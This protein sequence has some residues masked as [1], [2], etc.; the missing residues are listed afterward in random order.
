MKRN[1]VAGVVF[2]FTAA[3]SFLLAMSSAFAQ[4]AVVRRAT[5]NLRADP[6][7]SEPPEAVL[8]SGDKLTLLDPTPEHGYYQ[9]R[10]GDGKD[11]WVFS[12]NIKIIAS[13]SST[14]P[15]ID[16]EANNAA[17]PAKC[18]DALWNHVY[19]AHR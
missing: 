9:V 18:D 12:K 11:G 3:F 7:T 14:E 19:H 1:P 2:V 5:T 4:E 10:T 15:A 17:N 8:H 16:A 6:S 13:P